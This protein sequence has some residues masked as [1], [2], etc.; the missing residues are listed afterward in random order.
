MITYHN[1]LQVFLVPKAPHVIYKQRNYSSNTHQHLFFRN[2]LSNNTLRWDYRERYNKIH[3]VIKSLL[4][5]AIY[6]AEFLDCIIKVFLLLGH[7]HNNLVRNV[8][9]VSILSILYKYPDQVISEMLCI[10]DT[11]LSLFVGLSRIWSTY[12]M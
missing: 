3:H 6:T 7:N 11:L 5:W 1:N 12:S 9:I 2:G 10:F 4:T 8:I